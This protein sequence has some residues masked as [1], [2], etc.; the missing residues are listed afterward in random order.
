VDVYASVYDGRGIPVDG[1]SQ[2]RFQILDNGVP[3]PLFSFEPVNGNV[4]CAI[5]L[6]TTGSMRDALGS[7]KNGVS[8]LLDQMR[9]GDSVAI[10][11]FNTT[12]VRLQGFTT[13]MEAAKRA[14]LRTRA[15]GATALFDSIAQVADDISEK[16]GKKAIVLF[17]DGADNSSRLIATSAVQRVLKAGMPL[18]AIAEGDAI[19]ETK[20]LG[21]LRSL[22]EN[23]GGICYRAHST[24]Q[25]AKVFEDIQAALKHLYRFTYKPPAEATEIKWRTIQVTVNGMKDYKVRGKQG[26]FPY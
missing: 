14:V 24:K 8:G 9:P 13:D 1:L 5:L 25:M 20:L 16:S 23:T 22:A 10:Y 11:G 17:T 3:Q 19:N 2:D 15:G 26:Y 12:V 21:Q 18:Y 4:T 6:D 7:V